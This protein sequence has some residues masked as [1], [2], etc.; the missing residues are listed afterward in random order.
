MYNIFISTASVSL[1]FGWKSVSVSAVLGLGNGN[2]VGSGF[3]VPSNGRWKIYTDMTY[4]VSLA[5]IWGHPYN[6]PEGT[7]VRVDAAPIK[8]YHGDNTRLIKQ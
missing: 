2:G 7:W 4:K 8:T 3:R 1:S 5:N 6:S